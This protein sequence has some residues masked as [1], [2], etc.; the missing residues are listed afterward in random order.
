MRECSLF[1]RVFRW[2]PREGLFRAAPSRLSDLFAGTIRL[3]LPTMP[4][5]S[6][7]PEPFAPLVGEGRFRPCG[8]S[9]GANKMLLRLPC[10]YLDFGSGTCCVPALRQVLF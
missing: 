2:R 7:I 6:R 1:N 10:L 3:L 8:H 4:E 9:G 5:L